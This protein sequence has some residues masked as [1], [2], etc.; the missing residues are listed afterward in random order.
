M[1]LTYALIFLGFT[2]TIITFVISQIAGYYINLPIKFLA[3]T[4][5]THTIMLIL[6]I[7]S[8][9]VFKKQGLINFPNDKFQFKHIWKPILI[10]IIGF[11]FIQ[12]FVTLLLLPFGVKPTDT[13]PLSEKASEF[14][15]LKILLFVVIY[16]SIAE[17]FLF[18]GFLLN[19][20]TSLKTKGI[21]I[22][23]LKISL[24]V[25][26]SAIVFGLA[27]L[28]LLTAGADF[29]FIVRIVLFTTTVGLIAG[30]FYEKHQN[31]LYAIIVHSV[32]NIPMLIATLV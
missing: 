14:G 24:S 32:A 28:I 2:I 17:E 6:A 11:I 5:D 27:H 1:P 3:E 25:I 7:I 13:N 20:L 19:S 9:I 16:A 30:F 23:K 29:S 18:R 22:F 8:I 26:L 31:I 21:R 10:M 4:F 15:T 12:L